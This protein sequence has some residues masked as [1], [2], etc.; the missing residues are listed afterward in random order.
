M[1]QDRKEPH[2]IEVDPIRLGDRLK[3]RSEQELYW[4]QS[5]KYDLPQFYEQYQSKTIKGEFLTQEPEII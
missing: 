1:K 2:Y 4:N 5:K 3:K